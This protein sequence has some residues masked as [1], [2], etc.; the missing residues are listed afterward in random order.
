MVA[1]IGSGKIQRHYIFWQKLNCI[2]KRQFPLKDRDANLVLLPWHFS[3]PL[4][5]FTEKPSLVLA[6]SFLLFVTLHHITCPQA[7]TTL[8][9]E[10]LGAAIKVLPLV[11]CPYNYLWCPPELSTNHIRPLEAGAAALLARRCPAGEAHTCGACPLLGERAKVTV[12][13]L[14]EQQRAHTYCLN[15]TLAKSRLIL[16][17]LSI[18]ASREFDFISVWNW[19]Q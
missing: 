8:L 16:A 14:W 7:F 13:Q 4:F 17:I 19:I 9:Q 1:L 5:L 2:F 6:C 18:S 12:R 10:W 11:W 3:L 15:F